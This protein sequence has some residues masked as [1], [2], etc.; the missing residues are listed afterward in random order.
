MFSVKLWDAILLL[1]E[2]YVPGLIL[3][4]FLMPILFPVSRSTGG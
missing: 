3:I 1:G 2:I 4:V